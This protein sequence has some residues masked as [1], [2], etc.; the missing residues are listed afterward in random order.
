[1]V[2]SF[3]LIVGTEEEFHI[4]GGSKTLLRPQKNTLSHK[5][6]LVLKQGPQGCK[7]F[8]NSIPKKIDDGISGKALR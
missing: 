2:P 5:A 1:M 6:A 3:D 7:I 4:A 8:N